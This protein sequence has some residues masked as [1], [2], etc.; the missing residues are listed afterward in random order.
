MDKNRLKLLCAYAGIT[1]AELAERIGKSPAALSMKLSR[2]NSFTEREL[3]EI[4]IALGA[5]VKITFTFGD[6][7]QL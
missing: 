2:G 4:A 7:Q 6:G 5:Q 3:S 1:Q